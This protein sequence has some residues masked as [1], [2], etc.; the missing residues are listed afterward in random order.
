LQELRGS[1]RLILSDLKFRQS[2]QPRGPWGR[3][4]SSGSIFI[5]QERL[6]SLELQQVLRHVGFDSCVERRNGNELYT[7]SPPMTGMAI[8]TTDAQNKLARRLFQ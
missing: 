8:T 1:F 7:L 4:S 2:R 5:G 6:D 3:I